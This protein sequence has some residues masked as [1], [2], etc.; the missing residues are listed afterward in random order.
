MKR[1]TTS[2]NRSDEGFRLV[3]ALSLGAF[4]G[5]AACGSGSGSGSSSGGG[6]NKLGLSA[7]CQSNGDCLSG[8]CFAVAHGQVTMQ[9]ASPDCL[10]GGIA[11]CAQLGSGSNVICNAPDNLSS[12]VCVIRCS[13]SSDCPAGASCIAGGC[14]QP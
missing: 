12:H 6:V 5:I 1:S 4:F 8:F 7:A 2:R 10:T 3:S 9:C 14:Y 13:L 11:F